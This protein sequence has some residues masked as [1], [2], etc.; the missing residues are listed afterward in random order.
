M[1]AQQIAAGV[2]VTEDG[3]LHLDIAAMLKAAG[4]AD[5]PQNRETLTE[6]A[7]ATVRQHWPDVKIEDV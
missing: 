1:K 4:F 3:A 7:H 2:Y 5:T 6:A